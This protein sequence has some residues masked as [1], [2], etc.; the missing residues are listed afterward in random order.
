MQAD[1]QAPLSA[2]TRTFI[3]ASTSVA[4]EAFTCRQVALLCLL[5]EDPGHSTAHYASVM[6]T[7]KTVVTRGIDRLMELGL[8]YRRPAITDRRQRV[9]GATDAGEDLLR[10]VGTALGLPARPV[11][12]WG[13]T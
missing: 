3:A 9:L 7:S 13:T 4:G 11:I 1:I 12:A 8:C 2:L 6:L 10:K 5:A